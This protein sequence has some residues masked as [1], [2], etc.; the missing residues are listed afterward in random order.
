[1]GCRLIGDF[2]RKPNINLIRLELEDNGLSDKDILH[3][4]GGILANKT[5]QVLNLSKNKISDEVI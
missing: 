3:I 2:L 5:V 4:Y 1:M